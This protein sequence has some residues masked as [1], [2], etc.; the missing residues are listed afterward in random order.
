MSSLIHL[1]LL[2]ATVTMETKLITKKMTIS[3]HSKTKTNQKLK[4]RKIHIYYTYVY[5]Q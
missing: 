4:T 5:H 3:T 1:T 2:M